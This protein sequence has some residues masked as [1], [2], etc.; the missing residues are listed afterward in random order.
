MDRLS[1]KGL[2]L[3][4]GIFSA[5]CMLVLGVLGN[6]DVYMGAVEVMS[7]FH[8]FFSLSFVGILLGMIEGFIGGVILGAGIAYF[9]NIVQGR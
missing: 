6:L 7:Q 3:S 1:V 8:E 5:L 2:G 9:Y 4:L